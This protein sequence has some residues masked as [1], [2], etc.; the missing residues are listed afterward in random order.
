MILYTV[1]KAAQ[2]HRDTGLGASTDF[3]MGFVLRRHREDRGQ[4]RAQRG[5]QGH[6]IS[7]IVNIG[8]KC[9]KMI[10]SIKCH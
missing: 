6:L 3:V 9:A 2:R 4:G 10:A 8:R 5:F 7:G 1:F